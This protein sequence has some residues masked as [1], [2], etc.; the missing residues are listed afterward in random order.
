MQRYQSVTR[1]VDVRNPESAIMTD[2]KSALEVLN[3]LH[4]SGLRVID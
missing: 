4:R 3:Q 1:L 2:P